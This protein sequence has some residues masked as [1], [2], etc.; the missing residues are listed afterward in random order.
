MTLVVIFPVELCITGLEPLLKKPKLSTPGYNCNIC[1]K[2]FKHKQHHYRHKKTAHST[3][4][5]D[6]QTCYT[7]FNR[8]DNY[9]RHMKKHE[10]ATVQTGDGI[11]HNRKNTANMV[12]CNFKALN[13]TAETQQKD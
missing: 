4:R 5:F 7:Q 13:G 6:C 1:G 10:N 9:Q 3:E 11:S 2:I 12:S 8:K